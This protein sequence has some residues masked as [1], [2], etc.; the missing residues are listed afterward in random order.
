M[1]KLGVDLDG[2]LAQ[3]TDSYSKLLTKISGIEFPKSSKD[4]PE[5]W[6]YER[7]KGITKDDE[8]LAW[9]KYILKEGTTFW[10][11]LAPMDGTLETFTQLNR[12]SKSG[13]AVY[14][15]S[16]RHGH[17]AKAQTER[18]CYRYGI[19]YPTIILTGDKVPII[20][21]LG[22]TFFIDDKPETVV[23]VCRVAEAENLPVK[24]HVYLKDAPYNRKTIH[25][26][27]VNSVQEALELEGLWQP[28]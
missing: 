7:E 23:E 27:R 13:V 17:R 24:G 19:D 20:R 28:V 4:W 12:L 8:A 22:L 16:D 2:V 14:Y 11:S 5:V 1:H 6:Y 10:E 9:N 21:S 18:W 3:F 26:I 25:G 15:I